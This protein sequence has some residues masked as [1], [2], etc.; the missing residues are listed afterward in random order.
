MAEAPLPACCSRGSDGIKIAVR[1]K[2][3]ASAER[4][5]GLRREADGGVAL[6]VA[7]TAPP[8]DGKANAALIR[9]LAKL[10]HLPARDFSL[11]LGAGDRRKLVEVAGDPAR[12]A[13]LIS[14]GL[15]PW[16]IPE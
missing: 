4:V 14:E 15:R 16:S 6:A 9:L 11:A 5:I 13:P 1:L 12:L 10:F 2:P 8:V 3:R 7:V